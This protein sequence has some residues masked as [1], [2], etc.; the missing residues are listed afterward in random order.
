MVVLAL[1]GLG[2]WVE[3]EA[4]PSGPQGKAVIVHVVPGEAIDA[5]VGAL[6]HDRVLGN[7]LAFKLWA[8]VHGQPTI[9]P[10]TYQFRQNSSFST[11][12]AQLNAGPNVFQLDVQAG[13]TLAEV[14]NQLATLPGNLAVKFLREAKA[15]A[16]P[17]P[18]QQTPGGS[19]EGLIGTGAYRITPHEHVRTLLRA[20]V[21]RF[22]AQAAAAGL[23]PGFSIAGLNAYD[24]IIVASIA[25]KE[26]Y[27]TRYMGDVARV[28]YNRLAD[29]MHLDMTSTVLYSLGQDGGPVTAKEEA[30]TTPYNTYLHPGLTPTP[31]CTPSE[32]ALAAA[33]SP[34][35]GTWLYFELV[36]AK[37]GVMVFSA[38]YTAQVAAE[39]QAAANGA[40]AKPSNTTNGATAGV[41]PSGA[42]TAGAASATG[43][44][45]A[46][47]TRRVT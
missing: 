18:Y 24:A 23:P 1:V 12:N 28:V 2:A 39:Q 15:G 47:G 41:R 40:A 38:T 17:S 6:T 13:T 7:A 34:P 4:S 20:M 9:E 44:G 22:D 43:A 5:V 36:T 32:G 30:V 27:F 3:A 25:Q 42:G 8:V 37:K 16:V 33:A 45:A 10:G 26:G 29:G 46:S 21:A 19:L 31:I 11:V 14:A 35:A